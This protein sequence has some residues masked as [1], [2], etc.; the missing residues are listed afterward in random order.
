VNAV[1]VGGPY[2]HSAGPSR[3]SVEKIHTCGH[4]NGGHQRW[5]AT[6]I[7]SDVARR[8]FRRPVTAQ[9]VEK[10]VSLVRQVERQE[11][12]FAEGLAIGIQAILVSPALRI[13]ALL[14]V[15]EGHGARI[16]DHE[17]RRLSYFL[18]SSLPDAGL[19]QAAD[20]STRRSQILAAQV[21][22]M[23]RDQ[24]AHRA[25]RR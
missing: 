15:L 14:S 6:R 22:R 4:V 8:A 9:E 11:N 17:L 10:F 13:S 7:M 1:E 3:E 5:C 12:S 16:T 24:R 18:W 21:R 19:R 20:L 25:F 23:L 2:S